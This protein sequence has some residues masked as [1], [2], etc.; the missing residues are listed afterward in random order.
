[1]CAMIRARSYFFD[2]AKKS[3]KVEDWEEFIKVRNQ[4]TELPSE[5]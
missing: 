4:L 5:N 3:R 1:M 2:K